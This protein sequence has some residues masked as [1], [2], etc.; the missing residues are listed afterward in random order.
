VHLFHAWREVGYWSCS[1]RVRWRIS[2]GV[3]ILWLTR[4]GIRRR[5][6]WRER[7]D[8]RIAGGYRLAAT[9]DVLPERGI[10]GLYTSTL[11]QYDAAF[12]RGSDQGSNWAAR[13]FARSIRRATRFCFC[14]GKAITRCVE[15]RPECAVLFGAVSISSDYHPLSRALIMHFLN[16]HLGSDIAGVVKPRRP[17]RAPAVLPKHVK[18]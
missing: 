4:N 8:L 6:A 18:N 15:R 12:S 1:R 5:C 11:F 3:S 17:Y 10:R 16:G 13:S 2:T 14:Y 7:S 9:P